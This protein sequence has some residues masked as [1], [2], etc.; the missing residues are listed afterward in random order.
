MLFEINYDG[1]DTQVCNNA[2]N[3][4][5]MMVPQTLLCLLPLLKSNRRTPS[6]YIR[7]FIGG[8]AM[9]GAEDKF[10]NWLVGDK[11]YKLDDAKVPYIDLDT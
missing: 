6:H 10:S 9:M 3:T 2:G 8:A 4:Q 7:Q 11:Y 5:I 1:V